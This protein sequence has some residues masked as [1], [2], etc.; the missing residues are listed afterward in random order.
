MSENSPIPALRSSLDRILNALER[1]G[2][3]TKNSDH[4][5]T[6]CPCHDD[7][8]PSLDVTWRDGRILLHCF[9]CEASFADLAQ[10]LGLESTDLFDQEKPRDQW[11]KDRKAPRKLPTREK[12]PPRIAALNDAGETKPRHRFK[13]ARTYDYF[14]INGVL[15]QQV[16]REEC[17]ISTHPA[18]RFVQTFIDPSTGGTVRKKPEGFIPVPYRLPQLVEGIQAGKSVYV[19]EGEKDADNGAERGLVTTTNAQGSG[20]FTDAMATWLVQEDEAGQPIHTTVCIVADRDQ[21]GFNRAVNLFKL[22]NEMGLRPQIVL[23]ATLDVKSD[24]TDHFEAGFG[25]NDLIKISFQHATLLLQLEAS[26]KSYEKVKEA[27]KEATAQYR[28]ATD[29]DEEKSHQ[30]AAHTWAKEASRRLGQV[31][32]ATELPPEISREN[33]EL[34]SEISKIRENSFG[35]V[36]NT[37]KLVGLKETST[38]KGDHNEVGTVTPIGGEQ[39]ETT[40]TGVMENDPVPH[41]PN[42][43]SHF[44]VRRGE[45]VRV[46]QSTNNDDEPT[47]KFEAVLTGCWAQVIDQFVEDDGQEHEY[48]LPSLGMRVA[49]YRWK[50]DQNGKIERNADGSFKTESEVVTWNAETIQKGKWVDEI[51]W[52]GAS[53]LGSTSRRGRDAAFDGILKAL[54][55]PSRKTPKY[56]STGWRDTPDGPVFVHAHGVIGKDGLIEA[57]TALPDVMSVYKLPKP[58]SDASRLLSAWETGVFPMMDQLPAR[59]IMPLM[60]FVFESVFRDR[61]KATLH[62][63]GGRSSYKTATA[64]LCMQFFAPGIYFNGRREVISGAN[65]GGTA[66]GILR[67]AAMATNMPVLVDDFAPDGDPK[68]AQKKLGDVARMNYNGTLR[69]V[70]TITGGV[71]NDRQLR[72]GLITTGELGPDDSAETRLLT[73]L[74]SPG[75][76]AEAQDLF[77]QLENTKS[78]HAR[79]LL[80]SSLIQHLAKTLDKELEE[81]QY[82]QD[83]RGEPGNPYDYWLKQVRQLPHDSSLEGRFSDAGQWCSH[84]LRLMA[85]MMVANGAFTEADADDFLIYGDFGILEALKLQ[86]DV[87]GD[88]AHRMINYLR[89]A[90]ASNDA[91]VTT[92]DGAQPLNAE[93]AGWVV[94]GVDFETKEPLYQTA[95]QKI[96]ALKDERVYLFPSICMS[97][98]NKMAAA[99]DSTFGESSVSI[100][101]AMLSHNWITRDS[102]GKCASQRRISGKKLRVWDIP[103][104][105]LFG[106]DNDDN[107]IDQGTD[108]NDQGPTADAPEWLPVFN[109]WGEPQPAAETPQPTA[110]AAHTFTDNS[111]AQILMTHLEDYQPCV[112]CGQAAAGSVNGLAIHEDCW[113]ARIATTVEPEL[114]EPELVV[115][116]DENTAQANDSSPL[117]EP[118][119][120]TQAPTKNAASVSNKPQFAASSAVLDLDGLHVPGQPVNPDVKIPAHV[121]EFVALVNDLNLGTVIRSTRSKEGQWTHKTAPGQIYLTNDAT[122]EI[123][124]IDPKDLPRDRDSR[125]K[126]LDEVSK[127]HPFLADALAEG[128]E[129]THKGEK[130][131][132]SMRVYRSEEER[133]DERCMVAFIP[134]L[135]DDAYPLIAQ[136]NDEGKLVGPAEAGTVA[137]RLQKFS[138]ALE[139]PFTVSA[140]S[141]G[142]NLLS[143]TRRDRK[144]SLAASTPVPPATIPGLVL[145]HNWSRKPSAA[146]KQLKY[147]HAYDRSASYLAAADTSYGIGEA[148]H[149]TA[150]AFDPKLPGYWKIEVPEASEWLYPSIFNPGGRNIDG[151]FWY[152]TE[153]L[154]CATKD[155][156]YEIEPL[157]AYVW[158]TNTRVFST[159]VKKISDARS[160]LDSSDPGDQ[161]A[162]DVI[163]SLYVRT[164]GMMGSHEYHQGRMGYAPERYDLLK[165][166]AG[167]NIIRRI[168][169]I[170]NET[171]TWPLA[172]FTDTILYASDEPDGVKAWPGLDRNYGRKP[173]A[174]KHEGSTT[175]EQLTP[176]LTGNGVDLTAVRELL[177]KEGE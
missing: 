39:V 31:R 166:R 175:M 20:S 9:G 26:K 63:Q 140:S 132:G 168:L 149:L 57:E 65:S 61:I 95:G 28:E 36:E 22:F 121:G 47:Y 37:Y 128:W 24:L 15:V 155:L 58:T 106:N 6:L 163:K 102:D 94:R 171:G 41:Q 176:H 133:S 100:G 76:I 34:A 48:T 136:K 78:R 7:R 125:R 112:D 98:A 92:A 159:W 21:A 103:A 131:S 80:G 129:M 151:A 157:E 138:D 33:A 10:G 137:V 1:L 105:V 162:R 88:S 60:G 154:A 153:T 59:I 17:S 49:F 104:A 109:P 90:L 12:L 148:E 89:E 144:D 83:H 29:D 150:P 30:K 147:V 107:R 124:G 165:G 117:P 134:M 139:Y 87:A 145:D 50:R 116:S 38:L 79:A 70:G 130:I 27:T 158:P 86:N 75:D 4:F 122:C 169:Q 84:G 97:V 5:Q 119:S 142:L 82:W 85:R 18:K 71:K 25:V 110:P 108:G 126:L 73:L 99:A 156:G 74:L 64:N 96:G 170:G 115:F 40:S 14:D 67:T 127:G 8:T 72:T 11:N 23:P 19:V 101:S 62:L 45:I 68:K 3:P 173:G 174:Y 152:T 114:T 120:S 66:L 53:A 135:G 161:A 81:R 164:F 13:V 32:E 43:S 2:F 118:V 141:T 146:E 160:F 91:H 56:T 123:F 113:N 167:A 77:P 52:Y 172:V 93:E 177:N 51:P 44:A 16:I 46:T 55:S 35:L 111:G 54:P 143:E 69:S 42:T